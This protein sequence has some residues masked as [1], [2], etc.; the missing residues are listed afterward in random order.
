M[1]K[2]S[3][4][5]WKLAEIYSGQKDKNNPQYQ[6]ALFC[7]LASRD[8]LPCMILLVHR[9]KKKNLKVI[10]ED[11][12]NQHHY[13]QKRPPRKWRWTRLCLFELQRINSQWHVFLVGA[14]LGF[15]GWV[16]T[17]HYGS[18]NGWNRRYIRRLVAGKQP[19]KTHQ[20]AIPIEHISCS[21]ISFLLCLV[22]VAGLQLQ[23]ATH[24]QG[25]FSS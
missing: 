17:V 20:L 9:K 19:C 7:L 11:Q 3:L 25:C 2:T 24:I 18:Q 22:L 5:S 12:G 13:R 10:G 14:A 4:K 23:L 15:V 8:L 21:V 6:L 1:N 16:G